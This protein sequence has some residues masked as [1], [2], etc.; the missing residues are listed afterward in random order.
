VA[1][2]IVQILI[3]NDVAMIGVFIIGSEQRMSVLV[4]A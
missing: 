3:A 2:I 4:S 1:A